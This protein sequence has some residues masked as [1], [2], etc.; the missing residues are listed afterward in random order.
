MNNAI[1]EPPL[2]ASWL[3]PKCTG[4]RGAHYLTCPTLQLPPRP[5]KK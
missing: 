3:C 4:I 1:S 2:S 5:P